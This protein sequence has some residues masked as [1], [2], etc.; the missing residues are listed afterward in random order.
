MDEVISTMVV[1][2][3]PGFHI[4]VELAEWAKQHKGGEMKGK[5]SVGT[6]MCNCE[7]V[8]KL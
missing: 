7:I 5:T 3:L 4:D 6:C 2:A 8:Y 1:L